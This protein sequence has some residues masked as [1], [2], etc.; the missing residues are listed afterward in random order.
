MGHKKMEQTQDAQPNTQPQDKVFGQM[1]KAGG[2][3]YFFD[4]KKA[5]NGTN[6][7][8]IAE[9]YQKKTGEKVIN[10]LLIFKDHFPT[11]V[12]ALEEAKQYLQ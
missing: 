6:Y 1:V 5:S 10:R 2:K 12:G 9:S 3:N 4:V 8:T 7:L 11:F